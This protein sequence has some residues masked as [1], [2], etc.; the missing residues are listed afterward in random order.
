[1]SPR[2]RWA[3]GSVAAAL[4]IAVVL[5]VGS[6]RAGEPAR[7]A[8]GMVPMGARCCG[9]GQ[10]LLAGHCRGAPSSCAHGMELTP[11]GCLGPARVVRIE[12]GTLRVGPADWEAQGVVAPRVVEIASFGLD[13]VEVTE[14]AWSSCVATRACAP[15][16]MTG[17]AG[18]PVVSVTAAEAATFCRFAGG[19]LPTNDQ[20]AFA[21]AGN[22]GRRYAW[23][24][25]GAV[26]RRAAWGLVNGPCAWGADGPE[27]AGSH[28]DGASPDGALDLGGNVAEWSV[29]EGA[30]PEVRGGSYASSAASELRSWQRRSVA[31]DARAPEVGLRCVH[32]AP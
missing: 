12:G 2:L 31:P 6:R 11:L 4:S 30:R 16:A 26:C 15:V 32:A 24:D 20:L 22:S 1:M 29:A 23:G 3:T 13:A 7:C 18:R 8:A 9:G 25:T 21:A 17:E 28:P 14:A 5:A 10:T 19:S 27:L